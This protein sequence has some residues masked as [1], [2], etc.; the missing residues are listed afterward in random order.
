MRLALLISEIEQRI[1]LSLLPGDKDS[2]Q[3]YEA[4]WQAELPVQE[5]WQTISGGIQL[6]R[7]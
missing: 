2:A 5:L 6:Q 7:M 1:D 3:W 4:V